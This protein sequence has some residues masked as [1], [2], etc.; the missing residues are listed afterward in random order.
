VDERRITPRS[1]AANL[2]FKAMSDYSGLADSVEQIK[3][4][5]PIPLLYQSKCSN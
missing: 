1:N 4:T 2:E 5:S 3:A